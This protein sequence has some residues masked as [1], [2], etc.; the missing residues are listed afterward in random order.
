MVCF[1]SNFSSQRALG[2]ETN[3]SKRCLNPSGGN[4]LAPVRQRDRLRVFELPVPVGVQTLIR[5]IWGPKR[6][7]K[8]CNF[9]AVRQGRSENL[10]TLEDISLLTH[11]R[12]SST[13]DKVVNRIFLGSLRLVGLAE[14]PGPV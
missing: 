13:Q 7:L 4:A 1:I 12:R 6:K 2:T 5:R 10:E 11:G 3:G 14:G 8:G 9:R